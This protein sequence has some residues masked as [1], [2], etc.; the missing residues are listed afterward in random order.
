MHVK[1]WKKPSTAKAMS[2]VTVAQKSAGRR[3]DENGWVGRGAPSSQ[4]SR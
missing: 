4:L 2:A 1:C 3:I